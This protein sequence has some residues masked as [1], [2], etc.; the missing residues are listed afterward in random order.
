VAGISTDQD[1]RSAGMAVFGNM[2]RRVLVVDDEEMVCKA[3]K[4]VLSL[5]HHQVATVSSGTDALSAFEPG[6]FD[7]II[8]DYELTGMKG[9]ELAAAMK[10]LAPQQPII[11]ITAYGEQLQLSGGFPL[12][13]DLVMGKP[14]DVQTLRA[15]V[16]QLTAQR[17]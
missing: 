2:A 12:A 14:F 9:D 16:L 4:T 6:K 7:L 11:M 17:P 3:I 10:A 15:A 13:V 5:D 8:T 1:P